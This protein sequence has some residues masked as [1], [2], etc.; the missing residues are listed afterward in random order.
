MT[1][2]KVSENPVSLH[3]FVCVNIL[4]H[5]YISSYINELLMVFMLTRLHIWF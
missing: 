5:V 1:E 4:A 2:M 3:I